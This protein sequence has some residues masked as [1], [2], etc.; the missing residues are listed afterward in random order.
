L[1]NMWTAV[2]PKGMQ[3]KF[4]DMVWGLMTQCFSIKKISEEQST[5]MVEKAHGFVKMT[6]VPTTVTDSADNDSEY[7]NLFAFH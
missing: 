3:Y 5:L 7:E 6:T 4:N 2:I 1:G